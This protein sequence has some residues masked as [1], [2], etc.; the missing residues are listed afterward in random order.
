M[1]VFHLLSLGIL[2]SVLAPLIILGQA[3]IPVNTVFV[4]D[5]MQ[6]GENLI[7]G[8]DQD[9]PDDRSLV[10]RWN[11]GNV[12]FVDVHVYIEDLENNKHIYLGRTAD[13]N[14][15]SFEWRVGN[16]NLNPIYSNGPQFGESYRF[17]V[18]GLIDWYVERRWMF[19]FR[20][21]EFLALENP[22]PS[23]T[24][25]PTQTNTA[26]KTPSLKPTNTPT[27]TKTPT[28]SYTPTPTLAILSEPIQVKELISNTTN[29][30]IIELPNLPNEATKLQF[31]WIPPGSF[32]MGIDN[33]DLIRYQTGGFRYPER[34]VDIKYGYYL[35]K[36]EITQYQ[37]LLFGLNP[38]KFHPS[39]L[40]AQITWQEAQLF[41]DWLTANTPGWKFRLPSEA[42]WV[43][44]CRADTTT[45]RY[46]GEDSDNLLL[47][48]YENVADN[49]LGIRYDYSSHR[50]EDLSS[51]PPFNECNDGFEGVAPVGSFLPNPFGLYDMLGNVR[52]ICEDDWHKNY[53]D[54]PT[55]GSAWIDF[56][57]SNIRYSKGSDFD[58]NSQYVDVNHSH[59]NWVYDGAR[60]VAERIDPSAPPTKTPTRR[61][62]PTP[63]LSLKVFTVELPNLPD[64]AVPLQ[65]VQIPSG[66]FIMGSIFGTY[67]E[68][69]LHEVVL[70]ND[71]YLGKFEVTQSQWQAV[72]GN[73]PS[74]YT[75]SPN[76]P[77]KQVS[78]ND[79][80]RFIETINSLGLSEFTFRFPTEAEWEYA[81]R[82][83]TVGDYYWGD[84]D[85]NDYAWTEYNSNYKTHDVGL[86]LPN[87]FGL[88]DMSGNV[89]EWCQDWYEY[90][91]YSRSP[92]QEPPGPTLGTSRVL[93][94]GFYGT[95]AR[96]CRSTVRFYYDPDGTN[97]NFGF[98][99]A[100]T[101][102]NATN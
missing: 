63:T 94:G 8:Y 90:E 17:I 75:D 66:T 23:P 47:C 40:P 24:F 88:F 93:R 44:A 56:P 1:R 79:C 41:C 80:Q 73:N 30:I 10:I 14:A 69:P 5:D 89:F 60:I 70:N 26:T 37:F 65:L 39:N 50:N 72:M 97:F 81:C 101:I 54:L 15:T 33:P 102:K 36:Y 29:E 18:F 9:T 86:L 59:F 12:E 43:R 35:G 11:F 49:S 51:P 87:A 98:R 38:S 84:E 77:V 42:E 74:Y 27:P 95:G 22:T 3:D 45:R 28:K 19:T 55:D 78:W 71:F 92:L 62:T 61:P 67:N 99:V 32:M 46:W 91:Y 83:G 4:T 6:P 64:D 57:R 48:M 52:E 85:I 100:A 21:V 25:T 96:G 13:G 53:F 16:P 82:A 68:L 2:F 20:P 31:I 58:R 7:G 34:E 76:N